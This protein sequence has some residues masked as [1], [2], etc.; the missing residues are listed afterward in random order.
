[1]QTLRELQ[2]L[3]FDQFSQDAVYVSAAE[4][5]LQV[6]IQA[7]I[8]IGEHILAEINSVSPADYADVFL[9]LATVG[10]IPTK[11]SH[12]LA[13]MARFRNILVHPYL[14]A[15]IARV[16]DYL[17]HNHGDFERYARYVTTFLERH[18]QVGQT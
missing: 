4:R 2:T 13:A 9:K 18:Q 5:Q 16:H 1:M 3:T 7:A 11:F 15:D 10:V 8:D 6:A 14:E 12:K 17:Q